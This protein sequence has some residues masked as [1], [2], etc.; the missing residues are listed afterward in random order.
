[1]YGLY[2]PAGVAPATLAAMNREVSQV[3]NTADMR[4]KLA[5]DG[6]EPAPAHTP[7]EFKATVIRQYNQWEKF[8]NTSGV[9][10]E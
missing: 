7:A 2:A 10:L 1:M 3:M 4:D 8:I 6:A 5:A 9:K